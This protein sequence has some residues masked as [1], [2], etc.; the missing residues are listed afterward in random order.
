MKTIWVAYD[1]VVHYEVDLDNKE[2]LSVEIPGWINT[3]DQP[4]TMWS[5]EGTNQINPLTEEQEERMIEILENSSMPEP[6]WG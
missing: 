1:H 5:T 3:F 4:G 6:Y 2:V